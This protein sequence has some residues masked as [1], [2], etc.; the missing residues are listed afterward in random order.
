MLELEMVER[1]EKMHTIQEKIYNAA[2]SEV[3]TEMDEKYKM[4]YGINCNPKFFGIQM[5]NLF[6]C[7][8]SVRMQ[9]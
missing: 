5:V 9:T 4:R 2:K 7:W 6:F 3:I 8:I 1:K